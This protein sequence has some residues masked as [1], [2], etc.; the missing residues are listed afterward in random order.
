M[1]NT[2]NKD[3][4][5]D[6]DHYVYKSYE[7]WF[8]GCEAKFKNHL[9]EKYHKYLDKP[10]EK[11]LKASKPTFLMKDI[12]SY[13]IMNF[14]F[15]KNNFTLQCIREKKFKGYYLGVRLINEKKGI[16]SDILQP[17]YRNQ[18]LREFIKDTL[19]LVVSNY[20]NLYYLKNDIKKGGED[21]QNSN[22]TN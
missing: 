17:V 8:E 22:K 11:L 12:A 10:F 15:F 9:K 2:S 19:P 4:K 3:F 7:I 21:V 5:K 16:A 20:K 14:S 1:F 13:P 6:F 18:T